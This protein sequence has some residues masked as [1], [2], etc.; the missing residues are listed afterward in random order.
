MNDSHFI[1]GRSTEC[2]KYAAESWFRMGDFG[3]VANENDVSFID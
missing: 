2:W 1:A 3:S